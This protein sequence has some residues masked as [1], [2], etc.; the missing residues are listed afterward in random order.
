MPI[1]TATEKL[2]QCLII[3]SEIFYVTV[4]LC[5]NIRQLKAVNEITDQWPFHSGAAEAQFRPNR[6]QAPKFNRSP[7]FWLGPQI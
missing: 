3:S 6:D 5:L 7:K 4:V 2:K 1:R